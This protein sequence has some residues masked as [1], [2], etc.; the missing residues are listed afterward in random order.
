MDRATYY[1][2]QDENCVSSTREYYNGIDYIFATMKDGWIAISEVDQFGIYPQIQ[3]DNIEH[4]RD[5]CFKRERL[6][7]PVQELV[8]REVII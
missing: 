8:P 7:V 5:W 1:R 6:T 4:A 2:W 3:A